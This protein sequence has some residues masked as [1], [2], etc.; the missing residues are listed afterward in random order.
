MRAKLKDLFLFFFDIGSV[1]LK[2]W[3]E[4]IFG[5]ISLV[6][7]FNYCATGALSLNVFGQSWLFVIAISVMGLWLWKLDCDLFEITFA[8][9]KRFK[10]IYRQSASENDCRGDFKKTEIKNGERAQ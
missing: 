2:A 4:S 8:L 5:S 9:S 1:P 7:L 10:R 3:Q 6:A